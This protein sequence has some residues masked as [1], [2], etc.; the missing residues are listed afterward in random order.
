LSRVG[1]TELD[2]AAVQTGDWKVARTRRQEC[3]RYSDAGSGV[4]RAKSGFGEFSSLPSPQG[5]GESSSVTQ[6]FL[7]LDLPDDHPQNKKPITLVLATL[8]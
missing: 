7:R 8:R 4:Q 3:L 5:E 2:S 6:K 1:A